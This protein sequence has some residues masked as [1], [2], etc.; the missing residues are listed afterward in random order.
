M[1]T[2]K[3]K[4]NQFKNKLFYFLSD[5]QF[6]PGLDMNRLFSRGSQLA[7]FEFTLGS[8]MGDRYISNANFINR[9][10]LAAKTDFSLAAGQRATFSFLNVAPQWENFN[11][12]NWNT[13][14][15][16]NPLSI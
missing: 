8:S 4:K 15:Q 10:H 7:A 5:Q 2:L 11:G 3:R 1:I 9:G 13:L 12:G 16:V 14:E 6:F